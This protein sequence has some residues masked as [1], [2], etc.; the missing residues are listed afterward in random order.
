MSEYSRIELMYSSLPVE[1]QRTLIRCV[2]PHKFS[3][4][5]RMRR[6]E[7]WGYSFK[8]FDEYQCIF[9]H[10]PK[11]AGVSISKSLFG[12]MGGGHTTLRRY[13]IIFGREKFNDY[14]KF[15]FV[16]NPWD[17][18]FSAFRFLKKGGINPQ[19]KIWAEKNISKYENF[20][21]FVKDWVNRKNIYTWR[22]F[23]P[24]WWFVST[25]GKSNAVDFV[26][27]FENLE[28]DYNYIRKILKLD[29]EEL[30]FFNKTGAIEKDY[31]DYYSKETKSIVADVYREDIEMFGYDFDN[32][33]VKQRAS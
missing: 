15:A 17:R 4:W 22:H 5:Q 2:L 29:S 30:L 32:T 20:D 24:Q 10:I 1:I 11:T 9:V 33:S 23:I 19:D 3:K 31:K 8:P 28:R 16:R 21:C 7:K 25:R 26:G 14:F 6:E 18:L 13:Q 27:Y 12:N